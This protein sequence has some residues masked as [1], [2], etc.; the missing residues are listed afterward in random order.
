M[1]YYRTDEG[2]KKKRALNQR[3]YRLS[4]DQASE[5]EAQEEAMSGA[6][7][8]APIIEHVRMVTS[9]IE[10]RFVSLDEIMEMLQKKERQHSLTRR[11]RVD[12][13]V[14]QLN[15]SPP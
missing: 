13:I 12:Y 2:R 4:H 9:L 10:G 8:V 3:R 5:S 7:G 14:E 1:A 6:I 15:K 11:L